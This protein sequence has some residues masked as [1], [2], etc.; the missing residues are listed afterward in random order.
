MKK[1]TIA[2]AAVAFSIIAFA[3]TTSNTEKAKQTS[4]IWFKV[5]TGVNIPCNSFTS[6]TPSD[7]QLLV[8]VT[9]ADPTND[10]N[11]AGYQRTQAQVVLDYNCPVV[12]TNV[13][14]VGYAIDD[15]NFETIVTE[16]GTF[17][18][19]KSGASEQIKVCRP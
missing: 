4:Y 12:Q 3:F 14:A 2:Y 5:K 11:A 1:F 13:C 7:L 10:L 19:P 17:W 6:V 15:L 9:T 18:I 16:E 8:P